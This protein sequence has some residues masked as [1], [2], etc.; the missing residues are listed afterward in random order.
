LI[1]SGGEVRG[2]DGASEARV[3]VAQQATAALDHASEVAFQV[4]PQGL[5]LTPVS[6]LSAAVGVAY[7]LRRLSGRPRE[8]AC[9]AP[10]D[11]GDGVAPA[12]H[13]PLRRHHRRLPGEWHGLNFLV[14]S[15]DGPRPVKEKLPPVFAGRLPSQAP[16]SSCPAWQDGRIVEAGT[17]AELVARGGAYVRLLAD[18]ADDPEDD[19][20]KADN[21]TSGGSQGVAA[22]TVGA[23]GSG[24][25]TA[26]SGAPGRAAK[27][28]GAEVLDPSA[29]EGN[30]C[31]CV[32]RRVT[33]DWG[34]VI[35]GPLAFTM[36][37]I[38]RCPMCRVPDSTL[39][40]PMQRDG[41][42]G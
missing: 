8:P 17:H 36:I 23:R 38:I 16:R 26:E 25:G 39:S 22:A 29:E 2:G 3:L 12:L 28:E 40:V 9:E 30:G 35:R 5:F 14:R 4:R 31:R 42:G 7:P 6:G 21:A 34:R 10:D 19:Q 1:R 18:E 20:D 33:E 11:G 41:G 37:M 24:T 13:H 32:G 27:S 15:L